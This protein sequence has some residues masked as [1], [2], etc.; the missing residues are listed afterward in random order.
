MQEFLV[1]DLVNHC[2][3]HIADAGSAIQFLYDQL[4]S[5][6]R[7]SD[8]YICIS[9]NQRL[10]ASMGPSPFLE[11]F[12]YRN[13]GGYSFNR[14]YKEKEVAS[15]SIACCRLGSDTVCIGES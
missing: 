10:V 9:A 1:L 7:V 11:P 5:V 8:S 13:V 15:A 6:L 2:G 14:R 12:L 3:C 4:S